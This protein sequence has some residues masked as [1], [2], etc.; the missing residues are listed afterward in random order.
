MGGGTALSVDSCSLDALLST[1]ISAPA[2]TTGEASSSVLALL[3]TLSSAGAA[4][5]VDGTT[6]AVVLSGE[7]AVPAADAVANVSCADAKLDADA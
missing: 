7:A 2:G 6:S 3:S 5:S 1:G 4:V